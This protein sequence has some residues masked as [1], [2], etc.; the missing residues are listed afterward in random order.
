MQAA[1][2][3]T[4]ERAVRISLYVQTHTYVSEHVYVSHIIYIYT[5]TRVVYV[6]VCVFVRVEKGVVSVSPRGDVSA[7]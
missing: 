6:Y 7:Q 3:E 5:Y 1:K 4:R 2:R